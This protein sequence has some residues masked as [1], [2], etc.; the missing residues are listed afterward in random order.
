MYQKGSLMLHTLRNLINNDDKY[1]DKI[2]KNT[3]AKILTY[4]FSD[5]S[6]IYASD[7]KLNLKGKK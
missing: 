3:Q 4:G 5:N 1:A 2:M 7:I 6:N